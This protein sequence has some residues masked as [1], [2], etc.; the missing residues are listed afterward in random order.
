[1]IQPKI[2]PLSNLYAEASIKSAL[3]RD[4][5]NVLPVNLVLAI[6]QPAKS[7]RCEVPPRYLVVDQRYEVV[8]DDMPPP[9]L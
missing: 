5:L 4:S 7:A 3:T 6:N 9:I 8:R 1:V 2:H